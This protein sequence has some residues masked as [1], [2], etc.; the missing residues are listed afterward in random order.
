MLFVLI[1]EYLCVFFI[2]LFENI[3]NGLVVCGTYLL[4]FVVG[5]FNWFIWLFF[6]IVLLVDGVMIY[7][8]DFVKF[9]VDFVYYVLID[10]ISNIRLEIY[11]G[12]L[13]IVLFY[14]IFVYVVIRLY[15]RG[16]IFFY[17]RIV[18]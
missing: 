18:N 1:Y 16:Y 7:F 9:F 8:V 12:I 10:I 11:M 14:G 3:L 17:F 5:V 13:M 4:K 6:G 15:S 2:F